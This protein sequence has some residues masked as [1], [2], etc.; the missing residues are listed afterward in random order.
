[1][2]LALIKKKEIVSTFLKHN[3]LVSKELL[4]KLNK[5]ET[6]ETWH[7]ALTKG[8]HPE[9]LINRKTETTGS[10]EVIWDYTEKPHKRT[11]QDFVDHFNARYRAIEKILK[12][13]QELKNLTSIARVR[14]KKDK[15]ELSVIGIIE[16]KRTTKNEHII[17]TIEDTSG[18]I[19]IL[20]SKTKPE[21]LKLANDL[22]LDEIIGIS[23]TAGQD[24]IIFANNIII[25]DIPIQEP[26]LAPDDIYIAALSCVHVGSAIFEKEKFNNFIQWLN[27]N[28]GN[29]NEK[30]IATKTKYII[31]TGDLVDGIGIYPDQESELEIKD[32]KE[33]YN[34]F[35][36]LFS[37]IPQDKII[38][39][40]PGNHDVGRISEPQPKL[41]KEYTQNIWNLPN[42]IMVSNPAVLRIHKTNNFAGVTVLMYHGYSFDDYGEIVPSIR[43]S[44]QHISDRAPLIMKYLLQKR[45]LGPQHGIKHLYSPDPHTDSLVIEHIPDLFI[46]GHIHKAGA[47]QYRGTTIVCGSC[48]Q[49][50]T[51][52][53]EKVGHIPEPGVIPL[54]NLKTRQVNFIQF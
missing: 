53:Q 24:N 45:H 34:E 25:P 54:I 19:N 3:I 18:K 23:G 28:Y 30:E 7:D 39:L 9:E 29:Q 49:K 38:I 37:Q 43:E 26:K 48:F 21:L 2:E 17:L 41:N 36:R 10:V 52:F 6:V 40:G 47:L 33:Q 20:I 46:A 8:T 12:T 11:I 27:G 22:V 1:M 16:N 42:T 5:P 51:T 50:Q 35:A 4:E 15:E 13:R 44:G 31:V 32:I 14:A